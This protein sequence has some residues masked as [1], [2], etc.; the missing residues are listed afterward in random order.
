MW[1]TIKQKIVRHQRKNLNATTVVIMTISQV[2]IAVRKCKKGFRSLLNKE[3]ANIKRNNQTLKT[4]KIK[5]CTLNICGLSTRSKFTLN[6]FIDDEKIKILALQETGSTDSEV[7]E[8]NN[9]IH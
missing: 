2:A 1:K 6:K 9:I 4:L 8:L 3:M 7:L 5:F